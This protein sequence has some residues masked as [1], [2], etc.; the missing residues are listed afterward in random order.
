[1]FKKILIANR[2]EI[3]IRIIRTCRELG[4]KTVAIYSEADRD[5]MHVRFAD[6][7]YCVGP[8]P[9]TESYLN[10]PAILDVC[11][12]SG[13]E[14][15]HPGY[16][17]LSENAHFAKCCEDAK[18]VFIGPGINAIE[19]MGNKSVSRATV[20]ENNVPVIPGTE[21]PIAADA[22]ILSL[23]QDIGFP[24]MLKAAAGGGGKGMRI[25][26]GEQELED[27]LR[28]VK[29]E[30]FA[31]FANSDILLER[32]FEGARHI[33]IQIMADHHGNCVH[34]FERECS[35]QRRYQKVIEECP[36]PIMDEELRS[37]MTTA[38][39]RAAQSVGYAGA[40]TVEFLVDHDRNFYFLEMN[41]R[42][43][44]EHSVT[45]MVTGVDMVKEQLLVASGSPLSFRQADLK[46]NGAA[47]EC[48]LYA[49]DPENGF[50]PSPGHIKELSLPTGPYV[51]VDSGVYSGG[52]VSTYY[53]PMIAKI[54]TWG[55][56]RNEARLR[57]LRALEECKIYGIKSNIQFHKT[58]L[59]NESFIKGDIHTHFIDGLGPFKVTVDKENHDI[60]IIAAVCSRMQAAGTGKTAEEVPATDQ[61]DAWRMASKYQYWATRF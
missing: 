45:E 26:K 22:D 47:V 59:K 53:D 58:L 25:V 39:I 15:V 32:Y 27:A 43:Q 3:V 41:T 44:V 13:A 42:I 36:S 24:V 17:F 37:R 48:R 7:A 9:S 19:K 38:A 34:L 52:D 23:C 5:S 29:R 33:E 54:A 55:K 61:R 50:L 46:I 40:G 20:I 1:V 35:L 10:I 30:A 18:L 56:T 21:K 31:A 49:E 8:P 12:K 28:T 2:G 60:A 11:S 6:E 4:V 16:G 14:A 51:R 57:M